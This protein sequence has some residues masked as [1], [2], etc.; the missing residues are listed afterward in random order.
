MFAKVFNSIF[1]SSIA[2]DWQL[3]V[4]FQDLLVLADK[5]G[6]VDMTVESISRRTNVPLDIVKERI[7][8]LE[9]PD[10]TSRTP[11]SEGRRIMRIDAHRD[12]GWKITNFVKYR[13]SATKEMLRMTEADRKRTYRAK[14][15]RAPSPTPPTPKIQKQKQRE[16]SPG[17]VRDLSGTKPPVS[18]GLGS[19]E[20]ITREKELVRVEAAMK[21]IRDRYG[22]H[23]TWSPEDRL[24]LDRLKKRR[25]ELLEFLGMKV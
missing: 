12:W 7:Q 25:P 5:D 19:L 1:D 3:R 10:P 21:Q 17:P 2:D 22:D 8:K 9:A 15:N 14:F 13:E 6:L 20:W 23:R 24:E 4:V 11:D 18:N 16:N